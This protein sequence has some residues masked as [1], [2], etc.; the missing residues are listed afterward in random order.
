MP[1]LIYVAVDPYPLFRVDLVELFSR[2]IADAGFK[3]DWLVQQG[4]PSE[5][6]QIIEKSARERFIVLARRNPIKSL[7]LIAKIFCH[8]LRGDYDIVQVRDLPASALIFLLLARLARRP[9][10]YWMSFPMVEAPSDRA[11]DSRYKVPFGRRQM[12]RLYTALAQLVFYGFVIRWA[13]H[14]F[15]QSDR[16][17]TTLTVRGIPDHKVTPVP[18][19]VSVEIYNRETVNPIEDRRLDGRQVLVYMGTS[20]PSRRIDILVGALGRLARRGRDVILVIVGR[21]RPINEANLNTLA[22]KEE[23]AD[24]MIFT[25]HL[26]LDRAL[27]YV[28][29]A[30]IC[31]SPCPRDP[32][33]SLGTPT[34]LVEYLAMGR[35]VVANDHPD[36][37]QVLNLSGAG[38]IAPLSSEGF[39]NA[40][41][42]LLVDPAGAETMAARGPGWV[43]AHRSY[44]ALSK[45][46]VSVY[47]ELL[48]TSGYQAPRKFAE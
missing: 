16:M 46:V 44:A 27:G 43:A 34:K 42:K 9:F 3:I 23:V 18:M 41:D 35:P 17:K 12:I 2:H 47:A 29:R 15:V 19:G 13:D 33:L 38:L 28:R 36:Q 40:I 4:D 31:L 45:L 1:R 14:I 39:A 11:R 32:L 26:A 6:A 10:V 5:S 20:L 22:R 37:E 21:T 25:G 30:N 8:I 24:R 48:R 7:G